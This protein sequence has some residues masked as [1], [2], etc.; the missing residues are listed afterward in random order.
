MTAGAVIAAMLALVATMLAATMLIAWR[1]FGR[2]PHALSWACAFAVG[3]LHWYLALGLSLFAAPR[4]T[5]QAVTAPTLL[6][7]SA[8][9]YL[10]F[11]QRAG[12]RAHPRGIALVCVAMAL[13]AEA[14]ALGPWA[15]PTVPIGNPVAAGFLIAG[16]GLVRH[17]ARSATAAEHGAI[18]ALVLVAAGLLA[19]AMLDAGEPYAAPALRRAGQAIVAVLVPTGFAALGLAAVFLVAADLSA[20]MQ[21]L[22]ETDPLTGLLNRRGLD[23]VIAAAGGGW[24]WRRRI[25]GV[26]VMAD[27]DRFKQLNDRFGHDAGDAALRAFASLVHGR[28]RPGEAAARTGGEEFAF[29]LP[30]ETPAAAHGRIEALRIETEELRLPGR[31]DVRITASFGLAAIAS[32][33]DLGDAIGR[34]D[35][36][37]IEAK[38]GG[39]NRIVVA[40]RGVLP[41]HA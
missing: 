6:A 3:G 31:P 15:G 5:H 35:A 2:A 13:A 9:L 34:A 7:M 1:D 40:D 30:G 29:V 18:T 27:L 33:T 11:R 36:A 38:G 17:R 26:A 4:A 12:R 20:R 19:T 22:A 10:G 39:R 16:A 23:A 25:R 14:A 32:G 28:L 21:R 37:L 24:R 41:D 8:L